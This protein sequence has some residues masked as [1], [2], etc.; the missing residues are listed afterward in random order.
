[1][2]LI[3]L[4]WLAR[5]RPLLLAPNIVSI[6]NILNIPATDLISTRFGFV[7]HFDNILE[8][9]DNVFVTGN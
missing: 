1:M 3:T 5:Y 2:I 9:F 4:K 7:S 8:V 6:I